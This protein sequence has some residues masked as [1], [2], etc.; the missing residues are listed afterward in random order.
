MT[1]NV[2]TAVV[3]QV[4]QALENNNNTLS[5]SIN[6]MDE[7]MKEINKLM[8]NRLVDFENKKR[9]F[10]MFNGIKNFLFWSSQVVSWGTLG[11]LIWIVFFK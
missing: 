8:E 3:E 2:K 7:K 1:T 11:L 9:Q 4:S 5:N 10:F 6:Q